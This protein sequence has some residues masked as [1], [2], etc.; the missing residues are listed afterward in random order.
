MSNFGIVTLSLIS[1]RSQAGHKSEIVTQALFGETFTILEA[2]NEWSKIQLTRDGYIGWAQNIQFHHISENVLKKVKFNISSHSKVN[3]DG[4]KIH[5]PIGATVWKNNHQDAFLSQFKFS[6]KNK[7][8][9]P[10]IHTEAKGIIKV[11]QK[12]LGTPYLWGGKSQSG[13]DC[14]GFTQIVFQIN[15]YQLP[16]D[17]YQQAELGYEVSL[18]DARKGD[19]AFFS[20]ENGKII[21]VGIIYKTKSDSVKVIHSSGQVKIDILD[22]TGILISSD[23]ENK[24]YSHQ[25]TFIK[26]IIE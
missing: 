18:A 3:Y 23:S 11:A 2:D 21:H 4:F 9:R 5:L 19:L 22:D 17:A 24:K 7:S 25:L 6:G 8:V 26:R 12:F 15:G 14:S 10:N 20:N 1:L 16:R 13:I